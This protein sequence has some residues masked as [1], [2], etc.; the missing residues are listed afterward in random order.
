MELLFEI[1]PSLSEDISDD[2]PIWLETSKPWKIL[3]DDENGIQA[4]ITDRIKNDGD[5]KAIHPTA[6][7]GDYVS[8]EGACYIGPGAE[9]KNGAFLRRGSWICSG[10]IVGHCSEVKNSILLP[11]SK[12]PH[13]NYV[14]DSI[15]GS[16]ANLGAGAKISNVRNDRG[17][18]PV[19]NKQGERFDSGMRKLGA[20]VGDGSQLG[21]NVVTNPGTIISPGVMIPP[22]ETVSGWIC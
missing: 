17:A 18:I 13:F 2:I 5:F 14:G 22:N 12:A 15:I 19:T 4:Q 3:E 10:A 7:I 1:F 20:M 6:K 21:C 8:I 16:G 9:I 11:G